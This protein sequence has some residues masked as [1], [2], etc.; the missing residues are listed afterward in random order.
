MSQ[1]EFSENL[2][3]SKFD[4]LSRE[5]LIEKNSVLESELFL[6]FKEIYRLKNQNLTDEQLKLVMAEQL[7]EL[8]SAMYGASSERYKKPVNKDKDPN[9]LRSVIQIFL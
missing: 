5:A 9:C 1:S 8:Q 4:H 6:A 7:G 3:S 2:S